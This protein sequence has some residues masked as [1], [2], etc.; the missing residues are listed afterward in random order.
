M[1]RDETIYYRSFA[2]GPIPKSPWPF[3]TMFIRRRLRGQA[4][5]V[6][7]AA[8]MSMVTM[9]F[10]PPALRGLVNELQRIAGGGAWTSAAVFWFA[11]MAGSWITS[12]MFNRLH[13]WADL[14]FTPPLRYMVQAY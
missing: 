6:M 9:G 8:A 4:A 14:S 10:E 12:S 11:I 3:M 7:F 13:Q 1:P 5:W 2:D